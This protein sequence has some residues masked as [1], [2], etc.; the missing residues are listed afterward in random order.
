[1]SSR[2]EEAEE[3][4]GRTGKRASGELEA[5]E[6]TPKFEVDRSESATRYRADRGTTFAGHSSDK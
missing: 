3:H 1:M 2:A 5:A 6:T 4:G